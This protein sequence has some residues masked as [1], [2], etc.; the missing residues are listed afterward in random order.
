MAI[1][2]TAAPVITANTYGNDRLP[3]YP[4]DDTM[5]AGITGIRE[6]LTNILDDISPTEVPFYSK[7]GKQKM[8]NTYIEWQTSE[9]RDPEMNAHVEGADSGAEFTPTVRLGNYS[10]IH[11]GGFR[12]SGTSGAVSIA[13]PSK[14][15]YAWQVL[16]RGKE[17]KR[18]LETA[19]LGTQARDPGSSI[20]PRI[21]AGA[22]TGSAPTQSVTLRS[23]LSLTAPVRSPLVLA[24]LFDQVSFDTILEQ[25]F[26]KRVATRIVSICERI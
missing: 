12:C 18:D 2:N 5:D 25:D 20:T 22:V 1:D 14:R 17:L 6:D 16:Q 3:D 4:Y 15:E 23:P 24:L 9:L 7:C 26:G 10:Q 11:K 13:G 8:S 21:M 19:L